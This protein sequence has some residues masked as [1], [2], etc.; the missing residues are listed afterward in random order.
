[1]QYQL[2]STIAAVAMAALLSACG[3]SGSGDTDFENE[4]R[5]SGATASVTVSAA[6]NAVLNGVYSTSDL[7]LNDVT[8]FNPIGGEPETCRF[9]FS[10]L[11]QAGTTR[12]MDGDIRYIPGT[13]ETRTTF[14]S[15]DAV[16]FRLQGTTGTLV[17]KPNNRI[18]YSG[19]VLTSTAGTGQTITLSGAIPMRGD[20]PEGC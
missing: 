20:R 2:P 15:I 4:L 19:A 16:E 6:G 8:K 14:V 5:S 7:E 3:G 11:R 10:G 12:M 13:T 9:R 1:M 18:V 17:D